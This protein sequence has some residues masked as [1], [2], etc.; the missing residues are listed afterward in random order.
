MVGR[1]DGSFVNTKNDRI[2]IIGAYY[3][4]YKTSPGVNAGGSGVAAML[5]IARQYSDKGEQTSN[6]VHR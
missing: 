6:H 4:T 5:Q 3:D 2:L 1:K